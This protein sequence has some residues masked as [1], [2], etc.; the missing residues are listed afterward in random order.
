MHGALPPP[1][2]HCC[3]LAVPSHPHRSAL[4]HEVL[5]LRPLIPSTTD[6]WRTHRLIALVPVLPLSSTQA[7]VC[8]SNMHVNVTTHQLSCL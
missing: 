8:L 5:L 6:M 2:S 7:S 3:P 1:V 4:R